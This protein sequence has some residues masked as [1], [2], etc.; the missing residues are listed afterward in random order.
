MWRSDTDTHFV[1]ALL[2]PSGVARLAPAAGLDIADTLVDLGAVIGERAANE[3]VDLTHAR[4]VASVDAWLRARL[5]DERERP[6]LHLARAAC[7]LLSRATRVDVAADSLGVSRRHLSR[8][9]TRHIGVSPKALIDLYRLDRSLRAVQGG[10][11]AGTDGFADQAHQIREWK[12]RLGISPGR[13]AREG[14]S[15]LAEAF[16]PAADRPAFYL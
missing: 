14:R 12:R 2:T 10:Q 1:M 3:L 8:I 13:Y 7:S 11:T 6:E 9:V 4:S 5:L 15:T 16:D